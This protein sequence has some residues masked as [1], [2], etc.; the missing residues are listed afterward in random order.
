MD[1]RAESITGRDHLLTD[2]VQGQVISDDLHTSLVS[3][4]GLLDALLALF[5]ECKRENLMKNK[6]VASFVKKCKA[7]YY[8]CI[9][10]Y[11]YR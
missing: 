10:T 2:L 9:A 6:H 11:T 1:D 4:D 5:R 7:N 8:T 3:K